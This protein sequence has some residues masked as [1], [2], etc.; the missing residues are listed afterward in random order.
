MLEKDAQR[1]ITRM[2]PLLAKATTPVAHDT[3]RFTIG[4]TRDNGFAKTSTSTVRC[5]G[6]RSCAQSFPQMTW[7]LVGFTIARDR[8]VSTVKPKPYL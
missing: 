1:A 5:V 4:T 2:A 6:L 7:K 3:E 8:L